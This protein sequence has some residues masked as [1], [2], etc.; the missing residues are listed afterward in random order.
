MLFLEDQREFA[1]FLSGAETLLQS[2]GLQGK[3]IIQQVRNEID[4]ITQRSN[5]PRGRNSLMNA[6]FLHREKASKNRVG[7][8]RPDGKIE[9]PSLIT[10]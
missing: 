6:S 3:A 4:L 2:K 10:H 1:C 8:R 5:H 7:C 9:G